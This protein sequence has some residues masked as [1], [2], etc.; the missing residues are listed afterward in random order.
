MQAIKEDEDIIHINWANEVEY[1]LSLSTL[2]IHASYREGF[3]NVLLQAGA[4]RC[5]IICSNILG[6]IDI[7]KNNKTGLHFEVG[8]TNEL[9]E[10]LT[11][12]LNFSDL[13]QSFA[14]SL[15]QEIETKF[16]RSF[17]HQ[18][19]FDFYERKLNEKV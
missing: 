19:L 8:N 12:A 10:K 2:L 7:V 14:I 4:M 1:Y 9:V 18:E 3:P 6:N 11:F 15:K 5:P 17:I 16:S 13:M